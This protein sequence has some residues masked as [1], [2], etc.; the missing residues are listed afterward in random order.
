MPF[1]MPRV[2]EAR[3]EVAAES[4]GLI[5]KIV[6][7]VRHAHEEHARHEHLRQEHE[8]DEALALAAHKAEAERAELPF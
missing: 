1:P 5:D 2:E 6:S 8:L 4:H 3:S 7:I